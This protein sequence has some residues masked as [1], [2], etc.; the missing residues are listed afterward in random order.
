MDSLT[1]YLND[2]PVGLLTDDGQTM[3]FAY[4]KAYA[5]NPGNEPLSHTIPLSSKSF[6]QEAIEPFLSGL[7]PEDII[8]TRLGRIL[9]IP[10]D[11]TFAFLKAIGGDCAGAI[12]FFPKG[13]RPAASQPRFRRLSDAEAGAILDALPRRP[14]DIGEDGF[15]ISGAGAQDKLIACW[16]SGAVELPLGG[17][18][19]THIIK[20]AIADYPDSVENECYSMRL[21]RAC[22]L[23]CA[24]CTIAVIGGRRRYVCERYDRMAEDGC[25]RRL[26]QEDF[27]QLLH[28]EPKRKYESL[29]GPGIAE[30]MALMREMCLPASDTLE[31]L[32]RIVFMFLLGNG[33][34]HGKNYS[35]LYHGNKVSLSPMYDLMSTTIYPEVSSRMA[36][37]ID[38][39]YAFRWITRNKFL[40]MAEKLGISSRMMNKEIVRMQK[41]IERQAPLVAEKLSARFPS[42]CYGRIVEGILK[43]SKQIN[44]VDHSP[45]LR[46]AEWGK[47]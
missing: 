35:V 7:L 3:S 14:L 30:S 11:N 2:I 4:D 31:F 27:C 38:G 1:V 23:E 41:R 29:G 47:F 46:G 37:K 22:G 26:H 15:R 39:E 44:V 45:P 10:R 32:R 5:A 34:A 24:R 19:S 8:R 25:V 21:A 33:D 18:P 6:G 16:K 13:M 28:V 42:P 12:S 40:R 9:Q 36:M 17:T 20:P 43:R